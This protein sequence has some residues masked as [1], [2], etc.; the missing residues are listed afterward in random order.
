MCACVCVCVCLHVILLYSF[1]AGFIIG[2]YTVKPAR[3]YIRIEISIINIMI[4]RVLYTLLG[5]TSRL[6][7]CHPSAFRIQPFVYSEVH[8]C[9]CFFLTPSSCKHNGQLPLLFR[10]VPL[11][12]HTAANTRAVPYLSFLVR[13]SIYADLLQ[14]LL[15]SQ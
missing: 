13:N 6:P 14:L 5:T 10:L 3:L 12:F 11:N 8:F 15:L 2:H 4:V 1:F 7:P 9:I